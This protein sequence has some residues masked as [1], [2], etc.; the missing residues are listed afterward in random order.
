MSMSKITITESGLIDRYRIRYRIA[1]LVPVDPGWRLVQP[2]E[3]GARAISNQ[4][5]YELL[6]EVAAADFP[7]AKS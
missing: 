4:E 2:G 5:V 3:P 6:S 7:K 1:D